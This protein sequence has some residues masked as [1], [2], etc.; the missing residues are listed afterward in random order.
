M[1]YRRWT[2]WVL[3]PPVDGPVATVAIRLMAGAVFLWEGILKFVY[4]NQGVGRFTKLGMP[5]PA[6]TASFVGG[7][8]IVGGILLILGL[9]TR[10]ISIPFIVEMLVAMLS[11][12]PAL[13]LGT[14]PLPLPPAPPQIG[15]W[16]VL[17][18]IRS[19]YAQ[20]MSCVFLLAAGSGPLSLDAL[21]ATRD[22]S[23]SETPLARPPVT[24]EPPPAERNVA[25]VGT[26]R[27]VHGSK[28]LAG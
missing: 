27:P 19:E 6:V 25:M 17:H 15:M 20:L 2:A 26:A 16:V 21:L 7:L 8:E 18:E 5:F 14:S 23:S 4:T 24:T 22:D 9:G 28:A 13:F 3:H 1:S 11:T 10:L 12:K